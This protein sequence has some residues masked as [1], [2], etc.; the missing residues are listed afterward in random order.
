MVSPI[1]GEGGS[2]KGGAVSIRV[3]GTSLMASL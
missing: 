2:G 3:H 1:F